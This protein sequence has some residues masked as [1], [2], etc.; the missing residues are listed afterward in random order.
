MTDPFVVPD[1]FRSAFRRVMLYAPEEILQ[2]PSACRAV[3]VYLKIG[4]ERL[5]RHYLQTSQLTFRHEFMP[6]RK[7]VVEEEEKADEAESASADTENDAKPDS[8]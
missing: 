4:G 3:L 6:E 2:D 8:D 7:V 1:E 5:A